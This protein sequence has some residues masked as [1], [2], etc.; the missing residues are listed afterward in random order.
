MAII[1]LSPVERALVG[2]V[3]AQA[4][5][6]QQAIQQQTAAKLAV[7]LEAHGLADTGATFDYDGTQW[8]LT[9]PDTQAGT[10][11]DAAPITDG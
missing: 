7:I 2:E 10:A 3:A 6:A 5:A 1:H 8:V 9:L 4:A 11:P